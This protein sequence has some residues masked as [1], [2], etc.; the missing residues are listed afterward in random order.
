MGTEYIQ[1]GLTFL[2]E[3][4]Y[5]D[6][7][8]SIFRHASR[9]ELDDVL[10]DE[11]IIDYANQIELFSSI[12]KWT[13]YVNVY[14]Y[15]NRLSD[16]VASMINGEYGYLNEVVFFAIERGQE[17]DSYELG[18]AF[19]RV[20]GVPENRGYLDVDFKGVK[21]PL[22]SPSF[23]ELLEVSSWPFPF[24]NIRLYDDH[25]VYSIDAE[26]LDAWRD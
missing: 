17:V 11:E 7:T 6:M 4:G 25:Y 23:G 15:Y 13:A 2:E 22:P 21:V 10:S 18:E 1:K 14:N 26:Y 9:H 8:I 12:D 20:M 24:V 16:V 3:R 5:S 19:L